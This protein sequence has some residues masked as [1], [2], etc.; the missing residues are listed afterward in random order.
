MIQPPSLSC[1]VFQKACPLAPR[2]LAVWVG[3][4]QQE[5]Y[6]GDEKI[7][8]AGGLSWEMRRQEEQVEVLG[9]LLPPCSRIKGLAVTPSLPGAP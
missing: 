2:I 6:P 4:S 9:S 3:F 8:G 5:A 7:G 1:P